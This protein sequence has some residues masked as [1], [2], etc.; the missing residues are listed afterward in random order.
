MKTLSLL[1]LFILCVLGFGLG[2]N[3]SSE[4]R[5]K[6]DQEVFNHPLYQQLLRDGILEE[7]VD[8]KEIVATVKGLIK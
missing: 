1:V 3:N 5:V 4:A 8:N 6:S 7:G 2:N